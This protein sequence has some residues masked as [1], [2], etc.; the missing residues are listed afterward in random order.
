M[1]DALG[2]TTSTTLAVDI[3][4]GEVD[5]LAETIEVTQAIQTE[6]LP[7][8][9]VPG[10]IA[11][12]PATPGATYD[13]VLVEPKTTIVRLYGAARGAPEPVAGAAALLRGYERD[14]GALIELAG[15]PLRPAASPRRSRRPQR[16]GAARG[17]D[18]SFNFVLPWDWTHPGRELVLVGEVAPSSIATA[19]P[20]AA[21]TTT[22]SP[23]TGSS[24]HRAATICGRPAQRRCRPSASGEPDQRLLGRDARLLAGRDGSTRRCRRSTSP[25][26]STR[27][28]DGCRRTRMTSRSST[29]SSAVSMRRMATCLSGK[30]VGLVPGFCSGKGPGRIIATSCIGAKLDFVAHEAGHGLG[31]PTR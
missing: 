12:Q 11:D 1:R 28:G 16:A 18:G 3:I 29:G 21:P 24:L 7:V 2:R 14:G 31:S 27:S 20:S 25:K 15:S 5:Y 6:A 30:I 13:G 22:A 8:A 9:S 17:P 23:S 19:T 10:P 4:D 26:S